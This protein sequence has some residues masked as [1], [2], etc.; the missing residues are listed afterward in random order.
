MDQI[1]LAHPHAAGW[2]RIKKE[3]EKDNERIPIIK[4]DLILN[5]IVQ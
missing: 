4:D 2:E 5:Q 3:I 1:H